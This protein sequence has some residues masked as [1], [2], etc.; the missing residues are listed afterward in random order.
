[1]P[2]A[3]SRGARIH[4][5]LHGPKHGIPVVLIQG[6]GLS[7]RFWFDIPAL[8]AEEPER[9]RRVVAID[10][11]GTGRSDKPRSPWTMSTMADDIAAVL[12]DA[13]IDAA[14]VVGISMGGMV[15]QQVALRHPKRVLGL[16]LIATTSG[17]LMGALP[18]AKALARL[19]S[20][21]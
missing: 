10:N 11:R 20:L 7:S 9:P 5:T 13:G 15:A 14:Y 17:F 12:D 6:I 4:Y 16:V 8:L 18:E 21:P 1:M 19:V 3:A 2:F